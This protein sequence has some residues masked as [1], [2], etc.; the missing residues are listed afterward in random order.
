MHRIALYAAQSLNLGSHSTW[1]SISKMSYCICCYYC[2]VFLLHYAVYIDSVLFIVNLIKLLFFRLF[3]YRIIDSGEI[4]IFKVKLLVFVTNLAP[5]TD[6]PAQHRT[7]NLQWSPWRSQ[8]LIYPSVR[9]DR[10]TPNTA[11]TSVSPQ[12]STTDF[13][14][15]SITV[16]TVG[17]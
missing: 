5:Y 16:C 11:W 7:I 15:T 12:P 13:C 1:H 10:R 8:D 3:C 9:H 14:S 4:K 2:H 6:K 17:L